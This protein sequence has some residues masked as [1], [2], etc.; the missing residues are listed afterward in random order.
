MINELQTLIKAL[1][2]IFVTVLFL[3]FNVQAQDNCSK[4]SPCNSLANDAI[5]GVVFEDWNCDG[6]MNQSQT[7]GV[8]YVEVK[9][10]DCLGNE[11]ETALTDSIGSYVFSG[12]N[13]MET[14]R[15]EFSLPD[16]IAA[17]AN[18]S[19]YGTDNGT[20]VQFKTPG[21]CTNLGI[22]YPYDYC[23]TDPLLIVPC[24]ISGDPLAGGTAAGEDALVSLNYAGTTKNTLATTDQVGSLWGVAQKGKENRV[25]SS[26]VLKRNIGYGPLGEGGIYCTDLLSGTTTSFLDVESIGIDVG[27]DPRN[28]ADPA[29]SLPAD[30]T[31]PSQD[32][33]AFYLV[34]NMGIGD[35]DFSD[36]GNTMF[37][38]NLN[39]GMIY[40]I[41]MSNGTPTS[42]DVS[43]CSL[44]NPCNAGTG[45]AVPWGLK[46]HRGNLY[47]GMVCTGEYSQNQADLSAT[48]YK[49]DPNSCDAV[50]VVS[51]PL[52]YT[53]GGAASG[54]APNS[55]RWYPWVTDWNQFT[56]VIDDGGVERS[57]LKIHPQP[58]LSDIEFTEDGDMV[59]GFVDRTGYQVGQQNMDVFGSMFNGQDFGG[60]GAM[61]GGD[62]IRVDMLN[63]CS[64]V[65]E[66][67][68]TVGCLTSDGANN[69]EG[70][71]GGEFYIGDSF[72]QHEETSLGGLAVLPGTNEVI[73]TVY[74]PLGFDSGGL[75]W[76]DNSSGDANMG[77]A[78]YVTSGNDGTFAKGVGLGDVE[79][80]CTDCAPLEIGNYVWCDF[81]QNGLQDAC[82]LG[83][84]GINVELYDVNGNLVGITTTDSNGEYY[85][86]Q[87]N[88]D[89]T[90]VGTDGSANSG[91][92]TGLSYHTDY[93]IVF[94]NSQFSA[95]SFAVGGETYGISPTVNAGSN[96]EIDS[97][98]DGNNL[99][100][101]ITGITDGLPYI[102]MT[103]DSLGCGDHRYDMGVT[104]CPELLFTSND[105]SV[106][107]GATITTLINTTRLT[108]FPADSIQLVY[109]T[110]PTDVASVYGGGGTALG[111]AVVDNNDMTTH[112]FTVPAHSGGATDEILY[113][114]A[115]WLSTPIDP[116]CRPIDSL[117]ITIAP[118]PIT[119][120][121]VFDPTC[122][123]EITND[124]GMITLIDFV[125]D[126]RYD[127]NIGNTYTGSSTYDTA[128]PIPNDGI[129]VNNLPNPPSS[130]DYTIRIFDNVG[131]YIDRVITLNP[132]NCCPPNI[133]LP[134]QIIQN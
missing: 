71:D 12:L 6:Q 83:V 61:V 129:I 49:L 40:T 114:Y 122:V 76:L 2:C 124:D 101:G 57:A 116:N 132:A 92:Y 106:C 47:V 17:W 24:Y 50:E 1:V 113:V 91:N 69:G 72:G 78:L 15:I 127:Y 19:A 48:V 63:S 30:K 52:D 96:D 59:L 32:S 94:G 5:G 82:E 86:N 53:K 11:V 37:L 22:S 85:F 46:Y 56:P 68:G 18:P 84:E 125:A 115:Y 89:T 66:S 93:Y 73:S 27:D 81:N 23:Q 128:T 108:L 58:I 90:G 80:V 14:Y 51:F 16:S 33:L 55:D 134:I 54:Y 29:N 95:G 126:E 3:F 75:E 44:P 10:F 74:D 123:D 34:G 98:V 79:L 20:T 107:G 133:C 103:T 25:Y 26:A 64:G 62:I 130:Q 36:D 117:Q 8:P 77:Y 112:T 87:I 41:D 35:I 104:C 100:S 88:V 13:V 4:T 70:I 99:T 110:S 65:V 45:D 39:D 109:F 7:I 60:F 105:T 67:N 38:S 28:S 111:T 43:S 120:A 119:T 97:D 31:E 21:T 118:A 42:G 102:A 131:C 9:I 121:E